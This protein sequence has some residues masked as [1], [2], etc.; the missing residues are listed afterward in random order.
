MKTVKSLKL[1][2]IFLI[3][4]G[5]IIAQYSFSQSRHSQ[6]YITP[7]SVPLF[8]RFHT[9]SI[10]VRDTVTHDSIFHFLVDKLKLPVYYFPIKAGARKYAGVYAG[11]L[12]LEPCGPYTNFKYASDSF[13]AIFFGLTFEPYKSIP[14]SAKGLAEREIAHQEGDTY[15][16]IKD[17]RLCGENITISF[18]DQSRT[19]DKRNRDSLFLAMSKDTV[20]GPGIEYVKEIHIGYNDDNNL[21]EWKELICPG[22]LVKSKKWTVNDMLEFQFVR[23]GIKEV[24]GLTFKV[25]SLEK[26]RLYL[27]KENLPGDSSA[28]KIELNKI[29][30]FGLQIFFTE[31]E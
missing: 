18:I 24:Q 27:R 8:S 13:R 20:D 28:A 12:I 10:H 16:Y 4:I 9:L 14:L 2:F 26:A 19:E 3:I 5:I 15:I 21:Q 17:P 1:K 23:S 29:Q 30:A 22:K 6:G 31:K 7:E 11:N 25:R